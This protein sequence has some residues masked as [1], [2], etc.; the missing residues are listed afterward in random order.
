MRQSCAPLASASVERATRAAKTYV[1]EFAAQ[2]SQAGFDIAK[3]VAVSQLRKGHRQILVP[4]REASQPR[5]A[6]VARHAAP[7]LAIR[8]EAHQLG[9]HGSALIHDPLLPVSKAASRPVRRSNRGKPNSL[10]TLSNTGVWRRRG[11]R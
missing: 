6:A 4:T 1:V 7:E 11:S 9:E 3:A 8:Q 10:L 2:R 5:I